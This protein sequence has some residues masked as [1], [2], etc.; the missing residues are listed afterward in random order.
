[1]S[2]LNSLKSNGVLFVEMCEH[3]NL[4]LYVHKKDRGH[5]P[6]FTQSSSS[7]KRR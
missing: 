4:Y 5:A 1:M 2:A 3:N 7:Y 6:S